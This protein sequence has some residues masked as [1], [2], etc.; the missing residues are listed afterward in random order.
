MKPILT[1]FLFII[2]FS[3]HSQENGLFY[4]SKGQ[5][6]ADT[7][8]S[9]NQDQLYKWSRV[10]DWV[11][12]Y[13]I[14]N[15]IYSPMAV[16]AN[17]SGVSIVS[18]TIDSTSNIIKYQIIEKVMGGLEYEIERVV[19]RSNYLL[20]KLAPSDKK[21]YTYYLAFDFSIIDIMNEMENG[22]LPISTTKFDRVRK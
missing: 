14:N 8:L 6:K 15:I 20:Q 5:L 12:E 11:T 10:E 19:S 21:T 7:T 4:N 22:L 1:L 13:L 2:S 16:D 18:F 17:L 3:S 9:I